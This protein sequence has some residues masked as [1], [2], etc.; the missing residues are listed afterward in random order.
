MLFKAKKDFHSPH[1]GNVQQGYTID[2]GQEIGEQ[3]VRAGML[4]RLV[5]ENEL[6]KQK[7]TTEEEEKKFEMKPNNVGAKAS[8]Q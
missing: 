8:K 4:E 1:I 7:T 5:E 6:E 2:V 3:M